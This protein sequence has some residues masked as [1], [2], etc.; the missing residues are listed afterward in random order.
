MMDGNNILQKVV[1]NV[2]EPVCETIGV[3]FK[4]VFEYILGNRLSFLNDKSKL[5]Y[6]KQLEEYKNS[7]LLNYDKI[8]EKIAGNSLFI[9]RVLEESRMY[10]DTE[11]ARNMFAKLIA[12]SMNKNK[13]QI[14]QNSFIDTI[15]QMGSLDAKNIK[16]FC[17]NQDEFGF[18]FVSIRGICDIIYWE[19]DTF[20]GKMKLCS[21]CFKMTEMEKC[22]CG[23]IFEKEEIPTEKLY[24]NNSISIRNLLKLG[25]IEID[26][27]KYILGEKYDIDDMFEKYLKA[28]VLIEYVE[29]DDYFCEGGIFKVTSLGQNFYDVCIKEIK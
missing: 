18:L 17:E 24:R 7:I 16:Y 4:D 26:N 19:Q 14:S 10:I 9:A 1:D 13:E 5:K 8:E 28:E 6:Q 21:K 20:P 15:K 22:E 25:L 11:I 3:F 23:Y 12:N 2:T 29:T 27:E